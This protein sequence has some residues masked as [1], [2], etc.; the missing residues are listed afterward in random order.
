MQV[1]DSKLFQEFSGDFLRNM[2]GRGTLS[3]L[4]ESLVGGMDGVVQYLMNRSSLEV[5]QVNIRN[6][7]KQ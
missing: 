1:A 7:T 3:L 6:A 4:S 5:I 2:Y